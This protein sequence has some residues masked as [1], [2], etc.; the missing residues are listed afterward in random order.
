M[1]FIALDFSDFKSFKSFVDKTIDIHK[2]YKVGLELFSAEGFK[3]I[4]YLKIRGATVFLDLKLEDIPNTVSRTIKVLNNFD[5]DYLTLHVSGGRDMLVSAR[6]STD[7]IKLLGVTV[8]TS[9]NQEDLKDI[10]ISLPMSALTIKRSFLAKE[11]GLDGVV[12]SGIYVK[13]IKETIG[14]NFL[15]IVPGVRLEFYSKANDQKQIITPREAIKNGAD[16]LVIGRA[17]TNSEDPVEAINKVI[18]EIKNAQIF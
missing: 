18:L 11:C 4:E 7:R 15:T 5:I 1:F 17:I 8:L 6:E 16:F 9:L 10:G 14:R 3:V 13:K 2:L 12:V